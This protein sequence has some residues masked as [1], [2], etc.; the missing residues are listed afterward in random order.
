MKYPKHKVIVC[1][2]REGEYVGDCPDFGE[3]TTWMEPYIADWLLST[4]RIR[5]CDCGC[6]KGTQWASIK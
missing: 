3:S 4:G 6:H 5:L 1:D 2:G